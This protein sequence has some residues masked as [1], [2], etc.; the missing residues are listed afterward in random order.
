LV[1][2]QRKYQI[3]LTKTSLVQLRKRKS[4]RPLNPKTKTNRLAS[5]AFLVPS[6]TQKRGFAGSQL[7]LKHYKIRTL[8]CCSFRWWFDGR[9]ETI[10][11]LYELYWSFLWRP[12]WRGVDTKCEIF[13]KLCA[14]M[15]EDMVC[16]P[17]QE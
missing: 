15:E 5:N 9:R 2:H 10:H 6:K 12:Q 16:A 1:Q 14:G 17:F 13:H 3:C 4:K 7:R 8:T 11:W